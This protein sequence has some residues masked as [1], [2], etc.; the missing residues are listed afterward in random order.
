M[1]ARN[2]P[3]PPQKEHE[4]ITIDSLIA[5]G[6][7][8]WDTSVPPDEHG[9]HYLRRTPAGDRAAMF[10]SPE[11]L[12]AVQNLLAAASQVPA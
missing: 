10:W 5:E 8:A 3:L 2:L 7:Y 1:K 11:K 9:R 4:M 12:S 6:L